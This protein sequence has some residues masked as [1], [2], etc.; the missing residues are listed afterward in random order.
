M[1]PAELD[2]LDDNDWS[3]MVR[4]MEREIREANERAKRMGR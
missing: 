2:A 4:Y 1:T 3:A